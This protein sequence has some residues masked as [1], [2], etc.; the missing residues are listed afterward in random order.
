MVMSKGESAREENCKDR[1]QNLYKASMI[2]NTILELKKIIC[3]KTEG[4]KWPRGFLRPS[5]KVYY[6][7]YR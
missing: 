4:K 2:V 7:A 1:F 3:R 5:I 6:G